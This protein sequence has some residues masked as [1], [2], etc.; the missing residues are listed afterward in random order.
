MLEDQVVDNYRKEDHLDKNDY[1]LY[2]LIIMLCISA[3][4]ICSLF[5]YIQI[6]F[7]IN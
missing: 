7:I 2:L 1:L 3:M 5:N 6:L 4:F